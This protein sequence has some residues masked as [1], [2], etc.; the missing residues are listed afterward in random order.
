MKKILK[1]SIK[2]DTLISKK[3][4]THARIFQMYSLMHI[5]KCRKNEENGYKS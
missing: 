5:V 3:N 4:V 1:N 2:G